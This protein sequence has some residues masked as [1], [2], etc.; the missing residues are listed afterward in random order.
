MNFRYALLT[1]CSLALAAASYAAG[2]EVVGTWAGSLKTKVGA[3]SGITSVKKTMQLEIAADNTTTLTLNGAVQD[4]ALAGFSTGEI[5]FVY[6]DTSV[7]PNSNINYAVAHFK[8]TK[9][10]GATS[11]VTVSGS[12]ALLETLSGKFSLKKQN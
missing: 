6:A 3:P 4:S 11:G 10:K 9:A 8:G 7:A 5:L 2:P 1:G 12:S